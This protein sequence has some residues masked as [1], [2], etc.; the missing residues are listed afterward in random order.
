MTH[1]STMTLS[2]AL[3]VALGS[4]VPEWPVFS[5][6]MIRLIQETTCSGAKKGR[7]H[8]EMILT[9]IGWMS[10]SIQITSNHCIYIIYNN[11]Y[12]IY[13]YTYITI[14]NIK[15]QWKQTRRW[16]TWYTLIFN[17]FTTWRRPHD[18]KD[19]RA[20]PD[21]GCHRA[22]RPHATM[23]G[24]DGPWWPWSKMSKTLWSLH[25][26]SSTT[27][28]WGSHIQ[29]S[30][31]W[32]T[33]KRQWSVVPCPDRDLC[34]HGLGD[35][36]NQQEYHGRIPRWVKTKHDETLPMLLSWDAFLSFKTHWEERI[37]RSLTC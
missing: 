3:A 16:R 28:F 24:H 27:P 31:E 5:Q 37:E 20:C 25:L 36:R 15:R 10:S 32:R 33:T 1:P 8:L 23:T 2:H 14:S 19:S 4:R 22:N 26:S 7:L 18:W 13:I 17:I 12:I 21:W 6:F 11:K 34:K 30:S 9:S 35:C 29:G